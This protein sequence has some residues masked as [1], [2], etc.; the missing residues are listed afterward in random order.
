MICYKFTH[1]G[2]RSMLG[3]LGWCKNDK[4]VKSKDVWNKVKGMTWMNE[5]EKEKEEEKYLFGMQVLCLELQN[6]V[7]MDNWGRYVYF[8]LHDC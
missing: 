2:G 6:M 7:S 8:W 3:V 5:K 1:F 4:D